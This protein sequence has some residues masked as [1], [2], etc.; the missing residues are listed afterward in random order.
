MYARLEDLRCPWL[1]AHRLAA[2]RVSM[3]CRL[4][5]HRLVARRVSKRCRL[6]DYRLV[7]RRDLNQ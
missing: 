7:A 6:L 4:L 2:R 3:Q 1:K 5:V